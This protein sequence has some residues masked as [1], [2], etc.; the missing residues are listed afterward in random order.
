VFEKRTDD[1]IDNDIRGSYATGFVLLNLNGGTTR[2]RGLEFTLHGTPLQRRDFSWDMSANWSHVRSITLKLP[3][4]WPETYSSDTWLYGNVRNGTAPGLSTMSLMGQF[5]LRNNKGQILI[6]PTS[7]LPLRN[8]NFVDGGYDRQPNW[9][10]GLTNTLRYRRLSLDFLLDFRR[11]GDVFNATQHYLVARG[12]DMST[13][14][15]NTPRVIEGVLRD[16]KENSANPTKNN[17][18]VVPAV[19]TTYYSNMSEE[20]F[21]EKNINWVRLRDLTA[22]Y[23]LPS[24]KILKARD[25]SVFVTGTDLFLLTNYTGLDPIVNGNTAG[26]LGSSGVGIDLGNFPLPKG[27]N[28]GFTLKY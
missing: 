9:T 10:M 4:N 18:V 22:R 5:Y 24:G 28:F 3:N 1:Q 2:A 7:G 17:I 25:A 26:T 20:L 21:I 11:G 14:D 19:Q 6:D 27:V 23:Q 16:G 8:A 15:R 12:L 13:V